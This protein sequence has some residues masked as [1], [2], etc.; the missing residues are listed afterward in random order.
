[1]VSYS[2]DEFSC[3]ETIPTEA[4]RPKLPTA[5][6]IFNTDNSKGIS[7]L[8]GFMTGRLPLAAEV[9]QKN[10][11]RIATKVLQALPNP[12]SAASPS[13]GQIAWSKILLFMGIGIVLLTTVRWYLVLTRSS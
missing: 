3:G 8:A 2:I 4:F 5:C 9:K 12:V 1:M 6:K 7:D 13:D 11:D 10:P